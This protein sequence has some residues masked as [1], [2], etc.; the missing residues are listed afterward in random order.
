[1]V[2]FPASFQNKSAHFLL[3]VGVLIPEAGI[4]V[5]SVAKLLIQE[6]HA[7]PI[8]KLVAS[9]ADQVE[10]V[11]DHAAGRARHPGHQQPVD[12]PVGVPEGSRGQR[13]ARQLRDDGSLTSSRV[14]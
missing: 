13:R 12:D 14:P 6:D 7:S 8:R 5:S 4:C 3:T 2:Y 1:M 10:K 11:L 9:P